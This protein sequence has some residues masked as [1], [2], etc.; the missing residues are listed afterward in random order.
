MIIPESRTSS[1]ISL[2]SFQKCFK[3]IPST[4]LRKPFN[5]LCT[6]LI[7]RNYVTPDHKKSVG[8]LSHYLLSVTH[9]SPR[10][11]TTTWA[12]PYPYHLVYILSNPQGP[13]QAPLPIYPKW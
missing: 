5:W 1:L 9:K 7:E 12:F 8:Y 6:L 4:R 2:Q 13:H 3:K 10:G 11:K